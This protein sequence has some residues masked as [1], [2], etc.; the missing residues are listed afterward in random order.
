MYK[1][2]VLIVVVTVIFILSTSF[3]Q[4]YDLA[5]SVVRGKEAYASFCMNLSHGRWK[6]DRYFP[7]GGKNR[8]PEKTF[9]I[10]YQYC[11]AGAKW[12]NHRE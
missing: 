11:A 5:K 3:F 7:A 2:V 1:P 6:R 9:Q 8:L 4:K 10:S 12:G